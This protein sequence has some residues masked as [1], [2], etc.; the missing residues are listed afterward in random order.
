MIEGNG[1]ML[2][3]DEFKNEPSLVI[4]G[5]FSVREGNAYAL[6]KASAKPTLIPGCENL[7]Y[8]GVY[9]DG[10]IPVTRPKERISIIDNNG[11]IKGTLNPVGGKEIVTCS[12]FFSEGLLVI[13]DENGKM[14][15]AD[16]SGRIVIEPSFISAYNFSEGLAL[17][18][19]DINEE[20]VKLAIDKSGKEIFRVKKGYYIPNQEFKHGL[21]P[22]KDD[23]GRWGFISKKGEFTKLDSK[24]NAI[25][26]YN[27]DYFAFLSD[28]RLWGLKDI[29]GEV[30]IR[31]KYGSLDFLPDGNFFVKDDKDYLVLDKNGDKKIVIEDY[32]YVNAIQNGKFFYIGK[33]GAHYVLL[34]NNGKAIGKEE[35]VDMSYSLSAGPYD[36]QTDYFNADAIIQSLIGQL[37]DGGYDKYRVGMPVSELN[38]SDYSP[39]TYTYQYEDED[40]NKSGWRYNVYFRVT[41]DYSIAKRETDSYYN[42]RIV[43]NDDAKVNGIAIM[44]ES[45]VECWNDVKDSLIS[46]IQAKG[47]KLIENNDNSVEFS[48]KDCTLELSNSYGGERI[49]IRIQ[50][51]E[52]EDNYAV[53][54]NE[55]EA[56]IAE[57]SVD[58]EPNG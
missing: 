51:N 33:D 20:S 11:N 10:V 2:F 16:K 31:A 25:G 50:L 37:S 1:K 9:K 27:N 7:E 14:G 39:Y 24:V 42:Y 35:F 3:A 58:N 19:K 55:T 49:I 12:P 57:E 13:R 45:Q 44:V 23:N 30:L 8:V 48:G 56:E 28:D 17:V 36:V 47:Y 15:Y 54:A 53:Q 22:A 46:G 29:N 32:S 52:H 40:L 38:I 18:E 26:D 5:L 34:D 41:T 4:N 6:Y 21:L 43:R